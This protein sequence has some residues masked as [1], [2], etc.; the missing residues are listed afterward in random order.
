[1]ALLLMPFLQLLRVSPHWHDA[2][3]VVL[4]HQGEP[5][6]AGITTKQSGPT[7]RAP[8]STS[9]TPLCATATAS[10]ATAT[11][12]QA[13]AGDTTTTTN[14]ATTA[15]TPTAAAKAGPAVST[16]TLPWPPGGCCC[17]P[18]VTGAGRQRGV[19]AGQYHQAAQWSLLL[20][21]RGGGGMEQR[22]RRPTWFPSPHAHGIAR[23]LY[24]LSAHLC[25]FMRQH[26]Q[27]H[28]T[29][30]MSRSTHLAH[31]AACRRVSMPSLVCLQSVPTVFSLMRYTSPALSVMSTGWPVHCE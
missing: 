26:E 17:E 6:V 27:Q 5:C 14:A 9:P 2:L 30:M 25:A 12:V 18:I 28:V 4:E 21:L 3:L 24:T 15:A 7:C 1:M 16:S 13:P 31:P 10:T 23:V 11:T 20:V 19:P 29:I 22:C 8:A